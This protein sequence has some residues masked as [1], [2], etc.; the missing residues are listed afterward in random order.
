MDDYVDALL[1]ELDFYSY[2]KFDTLFIGG[3]TP[4]YLNSSSLEKLLFGISNRLKNSNI[5]EFTVECD[6]GTFDDE[7]LRIMKHNGVNRL[8]IGVQSANDSALRFIG[9]IHNFNDFDKSFNLAHK[10]G[11]KNINADLIF[12]LPCETLGDYKKS[13]DSIIDYDLQHI[14]AY[15]LILEEKTKFYNMYEK[16]ELQL[17]DEDIQ[18]EMYEYT[19]DFLKKYNFVQYEVSNYAKDN[20]KCLHNLVYW[21]FDDYLGI[22]V[23]AHSFY[24]NRRFKNTSNIRE[25][26]ESLKQGKHEYLGE[27]YNS[28][29]DNIKDYIIVGMRKNEGICIKDFYNRFKLKFLEIF[30]KQVK[31][32]ISRELLELKDDRLFLT[33]KGFVLMNYVLRDFL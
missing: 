5:V 10:I 33:T 1:K 2:E 8:S 9:R 15:N 25:Y 17:L 21:N 23:G 18:L 19:R 22:G 20:K 32:N 27:H 13:L 31:N 12:A 24:N 6:P 29:N 4:S 30:E 14:S 26:I 11:F 16:N 3:G 28:L 7:K